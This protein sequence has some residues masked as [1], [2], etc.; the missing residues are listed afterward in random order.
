MIDIYLDS[1]NLDD[2]REGR[3]NPLVKGFTTNP[4]ILR[5]AGVTDYEAFAKDALQVVEGLPISFEVFSDEWDEMERQAR[6]I[7]SWGSNVNVKIPITNTKGDSAAKLVR[8][9]SDD[10]IV[11]NVT[12]VFTIDQMNNIIPLLKTSSIISIFIGRIMDTGRPL[13]GSSQVIFDASY[14]AKRY[15]GIKILWAS[16][17][18]VF[19]MYQ[20]EQYKFDI[21]TVTPDLLAKYEKFKGKDLAELSLDTCKMFYNDAQQ[22]GYKL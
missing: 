12:A 5:K 17:R 20:A 11:C 2:M 21:I 6:K 8:K 19:N 18:E 14:I 13:Y 15:E 4:S 16:S 7:A 10:G 3:K 22:A 9:L 1:A